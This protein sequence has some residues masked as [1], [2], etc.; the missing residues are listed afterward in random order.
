MHPLP[1][2][3]ASS[4]NVRNLASQPG[5]GSR[6]GVRSVSSGEPRGPAHSRPAARALL[7]GA[8]AHPRPAAGPAWRVPSAHDRDLFYLCFSYPIFFLNSGSVAEALSGKVL[9]SEL[10]ILTNTKVIYVLF[11]I[12][13]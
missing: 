4:K 12:V 11:S 13:A 1:S 8:P 3:T 7:P 5:L 10:K 2:L 9:P 6:H